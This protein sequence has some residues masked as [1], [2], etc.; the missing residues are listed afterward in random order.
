MNQDINF[1]FAI[2]NYV[3]DDILFYSFEFPTI[4][5]SC[6]IPATDLLNS[7]LIPFMLDGKAVRSKFGKFL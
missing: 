2:Q 1:Y 6:V 3:L 5:I 7:L 4:N